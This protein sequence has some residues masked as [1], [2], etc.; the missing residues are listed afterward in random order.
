MYGKLT[1]CCK[2]YSVSI[3]IKVKTLTRKHKNVYVAQTE[4]RD[5]LNLKV[6]VQTCFHKY[7]HQK[8]RVKR[9]IS[10]TW[11]PWLKS[12][13]F[14][15]RA[16]TRVGTDRTNYDKGHEKLLCAREQGPFGHPDH[17][18]QG[19]KEFIPYIE[20]GCEMYKRVLI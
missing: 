20:R 3:K 11:P 1:D 8:G 13:F 16:E 12:Y 6:S 19:G 9:L 15:P 17:V 18:T 4:R 5:C 14:I 10:L 2:M 7:D